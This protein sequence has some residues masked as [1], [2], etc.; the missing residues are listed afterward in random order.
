MEHLYNGVHLDAP[1][2]AHLRIW[3]L[4]TGSPSLSVQ[5]HGIATLIK[6]NGRWLLFDVGRAA[7]QR[8][9]E[10]GIPIPEVTDVFLTHLHS[11]HICGMPD[12]W[13]TGWFVLHRKKP[14][15]IF[16]PEGTRRMI[17]G[18]KE[19]H[20]FDVTAR[21]KYETALSSGKDFDVHEFGEEVVYDEDGVRVISFLVDHGPA[22]R[23]AYGFR[24]ECAGRSVVLSGDTTICPGVLE[25]AAGCDVL[26]HEIAAASRRQLAGNEITRRI[27]SI[28]TD[29]DQMNEICRRA[30]PRLTLLNHVSL[31]RVTQYDILAR[32]RAGYDGA[33]ELALD[34][35]E[36]LVGDAIRLFPPGPPKLAQDLIVSDT[37]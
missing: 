27:L 8:M 18:L 30:R 3:T 32:V 11:D 28:H 36:V 2:D 15:R 26:I 31:W 10:C 5:R 13:M 35:M 23:P 19:L 1:L 22:V 16:G 21:S 12:F 29:P 25:H 14:L 6:A 7:L 34:R 4:G 37:H 33:V 9:Y 24:V 17:E 20:H